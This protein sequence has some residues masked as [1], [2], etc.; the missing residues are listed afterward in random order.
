VK[1]RHTVLRVCAKLFIPY[2]LLFGLYV[3]FHGDYGPGG[4]FQAGVIL[5]SA[6]ILYSLVFGLQALERIAKPE[7]L[8]FLAPAGVL[9]YAGVGVVSL[10]RG[11]AFLDYSVLSSDSPQHGQHLGI[12]LVEAGVGIT[13]ASVMIMIFQAFAGYRKTS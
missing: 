10:F 6:F 8:R 12:L 5:A 3:Q 1:E 9:F 2:I 7:L 13:V 4:G 11:G